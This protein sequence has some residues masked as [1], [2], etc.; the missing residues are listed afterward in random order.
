MIMIRSSARAILDVRQHAIEA[1][2]LAL[3]AV[4]RAQ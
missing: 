2:E 4:S 1:Q 3:A